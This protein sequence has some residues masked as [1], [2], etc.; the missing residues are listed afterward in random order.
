MVALNWSLP[1]LSQVVEKS[2]E[3]WDRNEIDSQGHPL[4]TI[5]TLLKAESQWYGAIAALEQLLLKLIPSDTEGDRGLILSSSSPVLCKK[6]LFSRLRMGIF[7]PKRQPQFSLPA[8][9]CQS[10][11]QILPTLPEYPLLTTDPLASEK[12][13]LALTAHFGL[14]L[15]LG[16]G[17]SEQLQ[18]RFS[19]DPEVVSLAWQT[20]RSRLLLLCSDRLSS[21]D[22]IAD[23]FTP[24]SPDYRLVTAF[25]RYL[26]ANLPNESPLISVQATAEV[27]CQN[28]EEEKSLDTDSLSEVELLQA[29]THEIRTP[30][31]TIRM[32]TRLLLKKREN[33]SSKAIERL[34]IIDRECTEQIDRMELIFRAAELESKPTRLENVQLVP[35]SLNHIIQ[36]NIPR[37]K[38]QA[39]GRNVTLDVLLPEQLPTVVSNPEMLGR[40][41]SGLMESFTRSLPTGG[42]LQVQ[43]ATAGHQLK[44]QLVSENVSLTNS[45]KSMGQLLVFQPETGNLSLNL[46]VTKNLFQILGGKLTIRQRPQ[47]GEVLTIFLPLGGHHSPFKKSESQ[48]QKTKYL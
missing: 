20:L 40:V 37:W 22:K 18:F 13:C 17:A 11:Q 31:T 34:E 42:Q 47:K 16:K 27:S 36:Q 28:K 3:F 29:L 33:L 46:D 7:T 8:T 26:L 10:Q 23:R 35:I 19:F 15:V 2:E 12:F 45:L 5:N 39:Q 48:K 43:V 38:K 30:L 44:L 9:L 6:E 21:L 32:L 25:G 41:L 4:C 14:V 24:P 1:T